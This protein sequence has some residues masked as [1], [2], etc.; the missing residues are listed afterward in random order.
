MRKLLAILWKDVVLRLGDPSVFL[1]A[2][3]MPLAITALVKLAFGNIVLGRGMPD[4]TVPVGIVN[5]DRGGRWGNIG[6]IF[7]YAIISGTEDSGWRGEPSDRLFTLMEIEEEADARRLVEK[8]ELMAALFIPPDFSQALSNERSTI[9]AY[10]NDRYMFRG[11]A[12]KTVVETLATAIST[13][14]VTVRATVKGL[15][16]EPGMRARLE[17]GELDETL[18]DLAITAAMPRSNPIKVRIAESVGESAQIEL[19]H[20]LAAAIA[21]FFS[22][23]TALL[24]SA[25]L[26]RERAQG[27]LQRMTI[28]PTRTSI[29]LGGKTLATYL[30]GLIQIGTLVAGLAA[31]E[32]VF[33]GAPSQVPAMSGPALCL[34]ILTG[35]A[36]ATGLGVATAGFART[37]AQAATYG[38][39]ILLLMALAGGIFFPVELFPRTMQILSRL[40]F[41]Y[42]A[43]DG[44][45]RLALG[46]TVIDI[47]PHVAILGSAAAGLMTG[48][49]W[50]LMRRITVV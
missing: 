38:A 13:G 24:G 49:G 28:T 9:T 5:Q 46:G 10:I 41:H 33:G 35:V 18:A 16:Q 14:E 21:I 11:V 31:Y 20:Y 17:S 26:L 48:G 29:T 42:W 3:V 40:T 25:S 30:K 39:G 12:F 6:E 34:L 22:G 15:L 23:Y 7:P 47:L 19:T 8:E 27:T 1:L 45:T 43:M 2:I 32:Y 4:T 37:Y 50:L 44:Y 36:A